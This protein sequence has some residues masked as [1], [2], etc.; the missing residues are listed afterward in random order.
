[1]KGALWFTC[2]RP[3]RCAGP[4]FS[5]PR[6]ASGASLD[7][8]RPPLSVR[9]KPAELRTSST[10]N[11][12]EAWGGFEAQH[13]LASVTWG[14]P[15]HEPK[16]SDRRCWSKDMSVHIVPVLRQVASIRRTSGTWIRCSTK[17]G[18]GRR[19]SVTSMSAESSSL[20]AGR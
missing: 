20:I 10:Q 12:P 8:S 6:T 3:Q 5:S 18:L 16:V 17:V 19:L 7:A 13:A 15:I 14:G 2:K 1:M 4:S 9:P 11:R